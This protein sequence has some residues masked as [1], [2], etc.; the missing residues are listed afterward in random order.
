MARIEVW[1]LVRRLFQPSRQA[2][3]TTKTRMIAGKVAR[4]VALTRH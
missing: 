2:M 3:L 4:Y 1:K